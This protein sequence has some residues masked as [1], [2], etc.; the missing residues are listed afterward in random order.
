MKSVLMSFSP[1]WYYLIGEGIKTEEVRKAIMADYGWDSVIKCYMTKDKKS[2]NRI[3]K[4][5]QEKYRMHIGKVGMQ[6]VCDRIKDSNLIENF[7]Y[8]TYRFGDMRFLI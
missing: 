2:F 1:Y 3:P 5:F 7:H 6:F 4:E 8:V